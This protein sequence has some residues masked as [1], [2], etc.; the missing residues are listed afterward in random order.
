MRKNDVKIL[1]EHVKV[2]LTNIK[3]NYDQSLQEKDIP[4]SL[5]VDIKNAMENLRSSLEYMAQDVYETLITPYRKTKNLKTITK[6]YFPYGKDEQHFRSMIKH[7]LPDL[8]IIKP[9]IYFLIESMQP[10]VCNDTWL[11]DF[12]KILNDNK[13]M[14]LSPQIRTENQTYSVGL[15]NKSAAI[16][17]PARAIKAPPGAISIENNPI[18]FDPTTGIP[19]EKPG[20]EISVKTWVSFLFQGTKR[21]VYPL[22]ETAFHRIEAMSEKFYEI[23][24]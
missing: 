17:A 7:N 20:L 2:K 9:D 19:K 22:L 5:C 3:K 15:R 24:R 23:I 4:G 18:Q 21:K 13:H 8:E 1:L 11:D 14:S 16:S 10:H 12:C 6:I